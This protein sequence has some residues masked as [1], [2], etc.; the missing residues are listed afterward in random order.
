ML[1]LL[2]DK[3]WQDEALRAL[4]A[5]GTAYSVVVAAGGFREIRLSAQFAG[6]CH[7]P[8][9]VLDCVVRTPLA[10]RVPDPALAHLFS[11][12]IAASV[13][14]AGALFGSAAL[15]PAAAASAAARERF[16]PDFRTRQALWLAA[17]YPWPQVPADGAADRTLVLA[18]FALA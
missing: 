1:L 8:G 4:L 10:R 2:A 3:R 18:A 17:A 15:E 11:N 13:A 16:A 5:A 9:A 12:D 6:I 7:D 14:W